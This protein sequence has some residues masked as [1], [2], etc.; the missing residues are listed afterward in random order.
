MINYCYE[1]LNNVNEGI[2]I[3][4]EN[5]DIFFWNSYMETITNI[6]GSNAIGSNLYTV[7]PSLN[8]N[9][10][11]NVVKNILNDG[12]A[13]FFSAAM[14]QDLLDTEERFNIKI[15]RIQDEHKTSILLE[16][17][18]VTGQMAQIK[19]L[20]KYIKELYHVNKEL[21]E[22][23]KEI[24]DLAYYDQLTGVANRT[25]FYILAEKYIQKAKRNNS[26]LGIMFI[27]I[28][29]FKSINDTYGHQVG[30]KII[31]KAANILKKATR[32][33][34]IVV[35]YGG[36]EFVVILPNMKDISDYKIVASKI[37][38]LNENVVYMED[39]EIKLSF[40]IGISIYPN[41]GDNID[42][43][44]VKADKAMYIAK[45]NDEDIYY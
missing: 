44:I 6:K 42:K 20:K 38:N 41:D 2:I 1:V 37:N 16:F 10:F 19:Q 22:K 9:Y 14:H 43:L 3:V 45:R 4:N 36:D 28:D 7:L 33:T 25:L 27:D 26:L 34:D 21:K 18:N 29:K 35:R 15:S 11:K 23:E 13:M 31:I 17:H 8:K 12:Y 5:F 30:D 39:K 40:S 24:E 32:E